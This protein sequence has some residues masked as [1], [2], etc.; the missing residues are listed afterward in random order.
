M[1]TSKDLFLPPPAID[2]AVSGDFF[3]MRF[4]PTR[5]PK[6]WYFNV[7]R[8]EPLELQSWPES[9]LPYQLV[10][11]S[12]EHQT[13]VLALRPNSD[14]NGGPEPFWILKASLNKAQNRAEK[15]EKEKANGKGK[16]KEVERN[17]DEGNEVST[18]SRG[19]PF[20]RATS[21]PA[22]QRKTRQDRRART[23]AL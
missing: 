3:Q 10:H 7:G 23:P 4:K 11:P 17:G 1:A 14:S 6:W 8:W 16:G 13:R 9:E 2:A 19:M 20:L 21:I 5:Q 18:S 12:E 15:Q 22:P